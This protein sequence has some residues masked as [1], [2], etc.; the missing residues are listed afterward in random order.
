LRAIAAEMGLTAPALYR[1]VDSYHG[2]LMLVAQAIF[3]DVIS[4]MT[5]ARN[6]YEDDDPAAQILA[7]TAAFRRWALT[8]PAEFGLI[9]ANAAVA[10]ATAVPEGVDLPKGNDGLK[11]HDRWLRRR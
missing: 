6:R 7:S 4:E 1:Y 8:H 3:A 11:G 5:C 9:F 2:L 10:E